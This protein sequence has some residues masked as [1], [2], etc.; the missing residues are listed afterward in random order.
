MSSNGESKLILR[1]KC[2][3]IGNAGVGKTTLASSYH[4]DGSQ[5]L[6]NYVMT[7]QPEIHV[8]VSP[9]PSD[10]QTTVEFYLFD[11]PGHEAFQEHFTKYIADANSFCLV[12]DVNSSE[13]FKS[14]SKWIHFLKK[15]KSKKLVNALPGVLIA[16]KL[17]QKRIV[18]RQQGEEFSKQHGL[19]YFE[20]SCVFISLYILIIYY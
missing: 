14:C 15:T 20:I 17:D 5:Y 4:S 9:V 8:K 2:I 11:I 13:S 16:N 1:N 6:K 19:G 3:L 18:T 7:V 12:F 10:S